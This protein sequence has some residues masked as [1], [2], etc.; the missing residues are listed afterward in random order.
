MMLKMIL[1]IAVLVA[2]ATA[3]AQTC[4]T[5]C[6]NNGDCNSTSC[7]FCQ[8]AATGSGTCVDGGKCGTA[9]VV[10]TDCSTTCSVCAP[11]PNVPNATNLTC[12]PA[13]GQSCATAADCNGVSNNGCGNCVAGKCSKGKYCGDACAAD[14]ECGTYAF[15]YCTKCVSG[16]CNGACGTKCGNDGVCNIN[17]TCPRCV[18]EVCGAPAACGDACMFDR[19]CGSRAT[20]SCWA[21]VTGKCTKLPA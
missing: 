12:Q 19:D 16:K 2:T 1:C 18:S 13:C 8:G 5:A 4:N 17:S 21:C 3:T 7:T 6:A 20:A 14:G 15:P 9:C 10:T 11:I